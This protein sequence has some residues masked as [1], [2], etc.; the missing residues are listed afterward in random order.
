MRRTSQIEFAPPKRGFTLIELLVV[1][2]IIAI[3]AAL[4][5]PA[6]SRAKLKATGA[7]CLSNQKQLIL[8]W[9]MYSNDNQERMVNFLEVLNSRNEVPWRYD[10]PPNPPVFPP[11]ASAEDQIRLNIEA[12][13]RQGAL[14]SYAPNSGIIH[15]PGDMRTGLKAGS[16]YTVSSVSPIGSLNG[17]RPVFYKTT[18]LTRPS[19]KFVWVEENDPRGENLGSWIMNQAGTFADGFTGS[20]FIDSPA[21][22]HGDSSSFDWADG[23]ASMHKSADEA[24]LAYARSMDVNKYSKAPSAAQVIHDAPWAASGYASTINP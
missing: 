15:C 6:L 5:L 8:A 3:L 10:P 4:L 21:A 2:A 9:M 12:G 7:A 14:Y 18:E 11:G 13:Y 24:T 20:R 19:E 16:G 22:F 23:H 1:I 17:E